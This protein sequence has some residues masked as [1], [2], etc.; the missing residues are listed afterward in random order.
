V[1]QEANTRLALEMSP[2]WDGTLIIRPGSVE[3]GEV[4]ALDQA[5][6]RLGRSGPEKRMRFA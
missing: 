5:F 2:S 6:R 4:G 1:D 3:H